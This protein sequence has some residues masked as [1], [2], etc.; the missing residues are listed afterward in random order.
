[1][2]S[3]QCRNASTLARHNRLP[4][5]GL[6]TFE[7]HNHKY[8]VFGEAV[9]H[10]TT[11]LVKDCFHPFD[12]QECFNKFYEGWKRNPTSKYYRR[13]QNVLNS[14]G[15]DEDAQG[16]IQANWSLEGETASRLGTKLHAFCEF[17]E[18][19]EKIECD[20]EIAPEIAQFEAFKASEW[21]ISRGLECVRTELC[22]AY[23][24]N[25]VNACAGQ[26]D[27][28]YR[29]NKGRFYIV[30][31]KRVQNKHPLTM[32]DTGFSGQM[33]KGPAAGLPDV[34][35]QH[36]S[37]QTAA[38]NIMLKATHGVDCS[39]RMYL[40]RMHR[41]REKYQL[42]KCVDLRKGARTMLENERVRLATA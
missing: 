31:F 18:N 12:A 7:A 22:V 15:T 21:A 14:G 1:M 3:I 30:D 36:Y 9:Q 28:L 11:A 5:D 39:D 32:E 23:R 17:R 35:F 6:I 33:G 29:D 38:Y 19:E 42:V 20:P 8:T 40:L 13:I 16:R 34:Q 41:D 2:A 4:G 24:V 25:G 10:S 26:I 37:L 27:A